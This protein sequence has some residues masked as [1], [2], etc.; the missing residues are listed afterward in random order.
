MP[1]SQPKLSQ[2]QAS[3]LAAL[4]RNGCSLSALAKH[5][6][7]NTVTVRNYLIRANVP[8]RSP[9]NWPHPM[10]DATRD[11]IVHMYQEGFSQERIAEHLKYSQSKVSAVL[12]AKGFRSDQDGDRNHRWKGGRTLAGGYVK[13]RIDYLSPE[14]AK[15]ARAMMPG[16]GAYIAEHRLVM[17]RYLGRPLR[18]DETVHH[19]DDR[20]K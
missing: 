5:F 7:I 2:E 13:L 1:G 9:G 16:D 3:E 4:Y 11:Q 20:D 8:R 14:D 6:D 18:D 17:A 15:L 10:A 12:K 19:V